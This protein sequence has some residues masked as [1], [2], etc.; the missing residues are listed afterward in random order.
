[1][2]SY[3][4]THAQKRKEIKESFHR[5]NSL[6]WKTRAGPFTTTIKT[7]EFHETDVFGE[8]F[9]RKHKT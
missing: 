4:H 9:Q 2:C 3:K 7:E 5:Q 6:C 1:M 8:G